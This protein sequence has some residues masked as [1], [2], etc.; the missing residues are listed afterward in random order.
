MTIVSHTPLRFAHRASIEANASKA[1]NQ[2]AQQMG[3][4]NP[5]ANIMGG[6]ADPDKLFQAEA[7]NLEVFEHEYILTGIEDRLLAS[8]A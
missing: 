4:M 2:M 8:L 7:E 6:N 3:Q 5:T 1:A